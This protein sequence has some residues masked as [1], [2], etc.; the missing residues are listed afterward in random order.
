MKVIAALLCLWAL[1]ACGGD[2]AGVLVTIEQDGRRLEV[3][4][5]VADE[6][7][8]RQRGLRHRPSLGSGTGMVFLFDDLAPR[9]FTM[10]DVLIPLD[11]LVIR[12][13][14]VIEIFEMRPCAEDP[15]N[16][17]YRTLPADV[18]LEVPGGSAARAGITPGAVAD[19][20][21]R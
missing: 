6:P 8:E 18:A 13:G 11:L 16:C 1:A 14:R 7:A 20:P 12:R 15:E 17:L 9:T 5:E 2:E 4:A 10:E 19:I 21:P 3:R